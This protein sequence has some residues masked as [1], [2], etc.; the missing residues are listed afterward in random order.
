M[1]RV[2]SENT[3]MITLEI[4]GDI[5]LSNMPDKEKQEIKAALSL[6]NPLFYKMRNSKN[7]RMMYACPEFIKYFEE[8]RDK[9]LLRIPR[10]TFERTTTF[11]RRRG[12]E[13]SIRD[14]RC[15]PDLDG[16]RIPINSESLSKFLGK[17]TA[18]LNSEQGSESL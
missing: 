15:F 16:Q 17:S 6:K 8:S 7:K 10:G 4:G 3:A 18:S 2:P 14:Q 11:M 13:V 1:C 5:T 9:T 12:Q